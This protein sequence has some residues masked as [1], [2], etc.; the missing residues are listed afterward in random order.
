MIVGGAFFLGYDLIIEFLFR[1]HDENNLRPKHVEHV[2]A[3]GILGTISGLCG[4]NTLK[5][6][7]QGL[8][9]GTLLGCWSG[10]FL[11]TPT[12][13]VNPLHNSRGVRACFC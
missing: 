12:P 7:F 4:L 6:G 11:S 3:M 2:V 9:V 5:G 8:V 1:H 10:W 13:G